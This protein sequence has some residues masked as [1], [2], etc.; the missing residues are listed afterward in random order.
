MKINNAIADGIANTAKVFLENLGID[1][2]KIRGQGYD[3]ANVMSGI[4]RGVQNLIKDMV[5]SPAPFVHCGCHNL[6]LVVHCGCHNLNLVVDDLN[7][8]DITRYK[9]K[10]FCYHS[11]YL[12]FFWPFLE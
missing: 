1:F 9:G 8:G 11:R 7:R 12:Q 3:C 6:N 4:H 2:T 5:N 10:F